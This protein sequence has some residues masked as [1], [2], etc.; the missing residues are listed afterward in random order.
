M[1]AKDTLLQKNISI[2]SSYN[3]ISIRLLSGS[4]I[5]S[6][7]LIPFL[8]WAEPGSTALK[9]LSN[10]STTAVLVFT[11]L[12]LIFA[13]ILG[14]QDIYLHYNQNPLFPTFAKGMG[15]LTTLLLVTYLVQFNRAQLR[16]A[17]SSEFWLTA[18]TNFINYRFTIIIV[19]SLVLK[20][21][22]V[23][24]SYRHFIDVGIMMQES[25][26]HFLAGPAAAFLY[27][28]WG[29]TFWLNFLGTDRDLF[30]L[31]INQK[32]AIFLI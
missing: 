2:I 20:I 32:R 21:A 14:L 15:W 16:A 25:S 5:L 27:C 24:S 29:H 1:T 8:F 3:P 23:L 4:V 30:Y 17:A 28:I 6:T 10:V 7:A 11:N 13:L 26:A 31:P 19:L 9:Y 12:L 22:A 18:W